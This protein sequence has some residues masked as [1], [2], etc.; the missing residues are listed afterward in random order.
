M[1]VSAQRYYS[2]MRVQ[3]KGFTLTELLLFCA[4]LTCCAVI[5]LPSS[6]S[7]R[8]I[9]NEE[10]AQQYLFMIANAENVW[11]EQEGSYADFMQLTQTIPIKPVAEN[12]KVSMMRTPFLAFE[13]SLTSSKDGVVHRG[14]YRFQLGV[15][16]EGKIV[17]CW[18]WPNLAAYSGNNTYWIDFKEEK[19][20]ISKRHYSWKDTPSSRSPSN[21]EISPL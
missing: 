13:P 7:G 2:F 12:Q 3:S 5:V 11:M 20:F 14:G 17:G 16:I 6:L 1:R 9:Q 10:G 19:L 15:D 4:L 18:A 8:V 21:S